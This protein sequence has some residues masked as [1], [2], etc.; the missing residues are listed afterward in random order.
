M[1]ATLTRAVGSACSVRARARSAGRLLFLLVLERLLALE[2]GMLTDLGLAYRVIDV[3]AGDL[4]SSAARKFDTEAWVPTQG[5]YR[6]L[7]STSNCTD[8]QTRRLDIRGRFDGDVQPIATLNGTLVAIPRTIVAILETHQ[9]AD[10]SVRV[11]KALQPYLQG[12]EVLEP[13]TGA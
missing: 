5:R 6:E 11:P 13:V 2:E 1:L 3:A 4:G 8:F 12:R 10:G 7:T 9:Q